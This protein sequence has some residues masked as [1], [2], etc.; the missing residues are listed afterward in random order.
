MEN[1]YFIFYDNNYIT[2]KNLKE[3]NNLIE[4]E[5]YIL[6]NDLNSIDDY[7]TEGF[8]F[9]FILSINYPSKT[10][11]ITNIS[12]PFKQLNK[13]DKLEYDLNKS[14]YIYDNR[15]IEVV[16]EPISTKVKKLINNINCF[17]KT[18]D[19]KIYNN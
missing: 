9:E 10:M 14:E 7:V 2:D 4:C 18:L 8:S 11:N 16:F 17:L 3:L 15:Y 5:K 6:N 1:T 19:G 12:E 13:F